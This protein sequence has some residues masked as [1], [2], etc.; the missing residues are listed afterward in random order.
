M[1][2]LAVAQDLHSLTVGVL[3]EPRLDQAVGVSSCTTDRLMRLRPSA[4]TVAS[5]RGDSPMMLR[6]SVSLSLLAGTRGL[7][8]GSVVAVAAPASGVQILESLELAKRV[9][10]GLE[11]V[12]R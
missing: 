12:V 11:D 8:H 10:G 5:C 7:L 4:F 2:H 6:V 9:D 1:G 3:D